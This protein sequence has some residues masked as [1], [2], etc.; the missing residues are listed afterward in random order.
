[1]NDEHQTTTAPARRTSARAAKPR[2]PEQIAYEERIAALWG[3]F[4]AESD[5]DKRERLRNTLMVEYAPLVKYVAGRVGVGL[6]NS[7]ENDDLTG[8]GVFGLADAIEKFEPE[9]GYKFETYAVQRI[10]GAIIDEL[11]ASDWVPRSVRTKVRDIEK[12]FAALE[13]ELGRTPTEAEVAAHMGITVKEL[14]T[15][16][17]QVS[18]T[19][20]VALDDLMHRGGDGDDS[21]TTLGD[22]LTDE[23]VELPGVGVEDEET[24]AALLHAVRDLPQ[25]DRIVIT[26]YY[27][28]NLTLAEIGQVLG[29]TESRVCQLHTKATIAL[30]TK[31]EMAA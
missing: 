2:T 19:N 17:S 3:E 16:F 21:S 13:T 24:K 8:M 11:R 30:R 14:Q 20:V 23:R 28:E 5:P 22:R 7:I 29:V 9:R 1:M 4:K 12:A 26:L 25:R 15:T 18:N 6:P 10:R 31:L 27:F